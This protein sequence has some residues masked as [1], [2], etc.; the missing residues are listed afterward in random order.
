MRDQFLTHDAVRDLHSKLGQQ[1][2]DSLTHKI[3]DSFPAPF[4]SARSSMSVY[5]PSIAAAAAAGG[6]GGFHSSPEH[7]AASPTTTP[8]GS[9]NGEGSGGGGDISIGNSAAYVAEEFESERSNCTL[10]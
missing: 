7:H 4:M 8:N 3:T 2:R 1:R 10:S 9:F 5:N 6:G